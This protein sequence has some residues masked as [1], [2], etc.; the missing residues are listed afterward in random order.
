[1][2]REGTPGSELQVLCLL[3]VRV[4]E[5]WRGGS[6]ARLRLSAASWEGWDVL[7]QLNSF[8]PFPQGWSGPACWHK[9]SRC[10]L[11]SM[12]AHGP[13][14]SGRA[15]PSKRQARLCSGHRL[16]AQLGELPN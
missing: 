10:V 3:L 4:P 14:D 9:P 1:M 8:I 7:K 13:T 5:L 16:L 11:A 15:V 6:D 12:A 2:T